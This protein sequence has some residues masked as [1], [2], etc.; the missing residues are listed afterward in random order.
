MFKASPERASWFSPTP[1]CSSSRARCWIWFWLLKYSFQW[2]NKVFRNLKG[3]AARWTGAEALDEGKGGGTI[4]NLTFIYS[5]FWFKLA[6]LCLRWKTRAAIP[7]TGGIWEHTVILIEGGPWS[8]FHRRDRQR[9]VL[10]PEEQVWVEGKSAD[11]MLKRN[12]NCVLSSIY[13][14][15]K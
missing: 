5:S 3:P 15:T 6:I 8:S 11:P 4:D 14:F 7:G 2:W 9:L 1:P 12:I 10:T 13:T